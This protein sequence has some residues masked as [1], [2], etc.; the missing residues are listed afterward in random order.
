MF[1]GTSYLRLY[2]LTMT[3][4]LDCGTKTGNIVIFY[5]PELVHSY[6]GNG[7]LQYGI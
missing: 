3:E 6:S 4:A 1:P 7:L 2:D 5:D